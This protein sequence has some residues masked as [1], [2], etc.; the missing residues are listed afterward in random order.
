[1]GRHIEGVDRYPCGNAQKNALALK[2]AESNGVGRAD[3][4]LRPA[5]DKDLTMPFAHATRFRRAAAQMMFG[6]AAIAAIATP[7][8]AVID[9]SHQFI[10]NGGFEQTT[11]GYGE[12]GY[13]A[14][15]VGW[16]SS[17]DGDGNYGYNFVFNASNA[18]T[19]VDSE[20]D[21][22]L[23]LWTKGNGGKDTLTASP[24]GGNFIGADGAFQTGM[25]SQAI[26]G[27][28][29]GESY[30]LTF[31]YA[32]AQQTGY[33]GSTTESWYYGLANNGLG[34]VQQTDVLTNSSKGFTGWRT[35]TYNFVASSTSDTLY[36]LAQGTPNG[37]PPFSL[38]DSVSLTGAFGT[39]SAAP[40]PATWMTM[41]L[42]FGVIG[43]AMRRKTKT[44][45]MAALAK[46]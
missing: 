8:G 1:L 14:N 4:W 40:D 10:T 34:G 19:G 27:L 16:T 46:A 22:S 13:A 35:E 2:N 15:A 37:Q 29:V 23:S 45:G 44:A 36:F 11:S 9:P 20:Y 39:V 17:R 25:I 31:N 33:T 38:L 6:A 7:A 18:K 26:T 32:G 5:H 42:G 30:S 3:A 12:L 21:G 43:L 24:T 41:M 28:I